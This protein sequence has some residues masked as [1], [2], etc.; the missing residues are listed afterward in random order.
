MAQTLLLDKHDESLLKLASEY[1]R[2]ALSVYEKI[3]S[4]MSDQER[5]A[6][7]GRALSLTASCYAMADAMVTAEGLFQSAIEMPGADP[8]TKLARRDAFLSYASLCKQWDKRQSDAERLES[9]GK[10]INDSLPER[11]RNMPG[12]AS[13]IIF[14]THY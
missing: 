1:S 12:I 6:G 14:M 5:G 4:N 3:E 10:E 11:W 9:Q 7:L 13:G 8:P 2:K